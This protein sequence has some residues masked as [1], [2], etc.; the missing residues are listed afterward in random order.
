[1][2]EVEIPIDQETWK[3]IKRYRI[4]VVEAVREF[5]ARRGFLDNAEPG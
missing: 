3:L 2:A 4:D 1:M 5:L